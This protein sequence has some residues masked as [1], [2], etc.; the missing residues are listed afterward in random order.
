MLYHRC[1]Q[2]LI[3]AL[4]LLAGLTGCSPQSLTQENV[5]EFVDKADNAARKRFAPEI[6]KLRGKN[7]V[8]RKNLDAARE[9]ESGHS[10]ISRKLYCDS[11]R[12]F[13]RLYQYVLERKSL[14]IEIAPGAQMARIEAEYVQK[15]PYYEADTMP[16]T[17]DDYYEVQILESR[18]VSAV[19]IEDGAIVFVSTD[20]DVKQKLVPK[21]ELQLPYN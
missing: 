8:L 5:T 3:L 9:Y 19:A 4:L 1:W 15:L 14:K 11:L 12:S 13:S 18:E 2:T 20:A 10:E 6:C 21:H 7:F 16:A 17:P